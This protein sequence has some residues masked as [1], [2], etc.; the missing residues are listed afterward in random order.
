MSEKL[1]NTYNFGD[2][3][4]LFEIDKKVIKNKEY[5]LL[6]QKQEPN[7]LVVGYFEDG[8]LQIV[9]NRVI[10]AELLKNFTSDKKSFF[11]KLKPFI[12]FPVTKKVGA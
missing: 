2:D 4:T 6:L 1:Y 12:K 11:E 5:L 9:V 8:K 7:L 10:S 3:L